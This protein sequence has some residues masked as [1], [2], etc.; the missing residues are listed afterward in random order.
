MSR[1]GSH[2]SFEYLKHKLWSKENMEV[3]V[4]I[5]LLIT[6]SQESPWFTYV[7]VTCHILLKSSQQR[8]QLCFRPHL[9]W[10]PKKNVMG[11]QSHKSPN[12]KKLGILG[13]NEIWV[14]ALWL[15]IKN[16]MRGEG[17]GFLQVG[18]MMSLVSLCM[19]VIHLC[20]KSVS[21]TH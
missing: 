7:K 9:N 18:V 5:W 2:I 13:Q 3:K 19:P 11:L 12:F 4:S 16:T 17:G 6:K 21:T 10:R 15:G 8:I 14:Q 20:T 1:M